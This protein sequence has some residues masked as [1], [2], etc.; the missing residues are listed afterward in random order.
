M[1][2]PRRLIWRLLAAALVALLAS[3][4]VRPGSI[5]QPG[6]AHSGPTGPGGS[7]QRSFPYSSIG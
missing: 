1:R 3:S 2:N 7:A 5:K 6:G 4:D